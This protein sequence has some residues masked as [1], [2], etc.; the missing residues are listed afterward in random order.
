M[1]GS[2]GG[3]PAAGFDDANE[4]NNT[5]NEN[6]NTTSSYIAKADA[7]SSQNL[8]PDNNVA[9]ENLMSGYFWGSVGSGIDLTYSFMSTGS[10]FAADYDGDG[11]S[12]DSEVP[13]NI[14]NS[15]SIF[16]STVA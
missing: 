1:T 9:I 10:N 13:D 11:S 3:S 7:A 5:S 14:Q 8:N 12:S 4:A 2:I 6:Q 15:S 16:Q